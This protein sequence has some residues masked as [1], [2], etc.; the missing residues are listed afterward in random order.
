L[1]FAPELPLKQQP[2]QTTKNK[3]VRKLS[4]N[5]NI[6]EDIKFKY[7]RLELKEDIF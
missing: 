5:M 1:S 3:N 4:F 6:E 7:M 2:P